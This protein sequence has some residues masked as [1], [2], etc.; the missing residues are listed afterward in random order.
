MKYT[1]ALWIKLLCQITNSKQFYCLV[2][3]RKVNR[4]IISKWPHC[5]NHETRLITD[6]LLLNSWTILYVLINVRYHY[7]LLY[8][9]VVDLFVLSH[10]PSLD[11]SLCTSH[12]LA[13]QVLC[14]SISHKNQ[15]FHGTFLNLTHEYLHAT[16]RGLSCMSEVIVG[17]YCSL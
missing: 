11:L 6:W 3:M 5:E 16:M 13:L 17:T 8:A 4:K 14:Y 1:V 7:A 2:H 9:I 15:D 10:K 12:L